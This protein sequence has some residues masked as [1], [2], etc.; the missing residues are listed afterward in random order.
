MHKSNANVVIEAVQFSLQANEVQVI[1]SS[2]RNTNKQAPPSAYFLNLA[3]KKENL[4][5]DFSGQ[6]V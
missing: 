1:N 3:I 5:A 2:R 6:Y 4:K